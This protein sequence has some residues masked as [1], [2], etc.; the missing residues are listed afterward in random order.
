MRVSSR[1]RNGIIYQ[2]GMR[3]TAL[4]RPMTMAPGRDMY[5]LR[6]SLGGVTPALVNLSSMPPGSQRC[7]E[8]SRRCITG[9]VRLSTSP[10]KL[11]GWVT[12]TEDPSVRI[13]PRASQNSPSKATLRGS[14]CCHPKPAPFVTVV[15]DSIR[16]RSCQTVVFVWSEK[17]ILTV[18]TVVMVLP[19][20]KV[21]VA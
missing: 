7:I 1:L 11:V 2:G 12:R 18:P 16:Q 13:G 10:E 15:L 21:I 19:P 20:A 8:R 17:T 14:Q 4:T 5:P 3:G 6:S 9:L